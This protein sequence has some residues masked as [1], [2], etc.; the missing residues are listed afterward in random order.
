MRNFVTGVTANGLMVSQLQPSGGA[1]CDGVTAVTAAP[2]TYTHTHLRARMH[3]N[4]YIG[5]TGVTG[6]ISQY[7][8][9]F[10]A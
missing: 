9:G 2:R 6:V 1:A 5:V 4:V 7:H 8:Q 3:M 10:E